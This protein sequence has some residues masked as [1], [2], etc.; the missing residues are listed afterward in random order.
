MGI[1]VIFDLETTGLDKTKDQI[2]QFSG[3][4]I[5]TD[6]N[7]IIDSLN[8]Y[9]Q[10]LGE[11]SI[12]IG[13]FN[14]H[15]IH[16]NFLKDKPYLKDIAQQIIDFIGNYDILTYNGLSFDIPFLKNELHKYGYDINFM[17]RKCYDA[18]LEE[19]RR[20]GISLENTYKR[21]KGKSMEDAGLSAHDATSDIKATYSIFIAQQRIKSYDAEK[22]YGEDNF[23]EDMEF[24]NE[25]KPCFCVGKYKGASL[26]YIAKYDQGY[27]KWCISDKSKLMESTKNY[28]KN[29]IK[30]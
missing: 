12:S 26:E 21:Y 9:I 14:K 28:I 10:P 16:P 18:F 27:L 23:I 5:N 22:M 19:K 1:L 20:N 24:N 6:T 13:A 17:N 30:N 25:I 29:Y 15:H 3:I 7:K 8:L 11:Y 2:I 4:K